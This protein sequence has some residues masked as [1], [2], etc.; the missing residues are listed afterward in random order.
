MYMLGSFG[1]RFDG[2]FWGMFGPKIV[3]MYLDLQT[4]F[5][6]ILISLGFL[7]INKSLKDSFYL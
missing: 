6:F 7:F 3:H 5:S 4:L 2:P 1:M